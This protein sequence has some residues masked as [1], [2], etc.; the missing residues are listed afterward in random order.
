MAAVLL[1]QPE[2]ARRASTRARTGVQRGWTPCRFDDPG[3][4][5]SRGERGRPVVRQ[6]YSSPR[7]ENVDRVVALLAEAGIETSVTNR[8][9]WAGHDFKGPSYAN[10]PDP[11]TWP[12][13][14]VVKAE[15][16]PRARAL[17]REIGI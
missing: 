3:R 9:A 7:V 17:L 8:R 14:W 6:I 10:R 1:R 11:S 13:V 5:D 4:H 15:D 12:Q 16:Q 2:R